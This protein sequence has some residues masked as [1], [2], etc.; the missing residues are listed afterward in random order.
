MDERAESRPER[1]PDHAGDVDDL[2]VDVLKV[3]Q[4]QLAIRRHLRHG[5]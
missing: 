5:P 2:D 4:R 3:E 1:P